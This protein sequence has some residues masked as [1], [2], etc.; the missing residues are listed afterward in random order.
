MKKQR[1]VGL[2]RNEE[3]TPVREWAAQRVRPGRLVGEKEPR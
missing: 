2:C 3:G 1:K